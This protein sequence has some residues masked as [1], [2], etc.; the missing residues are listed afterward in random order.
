MDLL[1]DR[2]TD[3][4]NASSVPCFRQVF[5]WDPGEGMIAVA[6]LT[7]TE[8]DEEQQHSMAEASPVDRAFSKKVSGPTG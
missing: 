6:V 4:R 2:S 5:A 1:A 7:L 8:A 3:H